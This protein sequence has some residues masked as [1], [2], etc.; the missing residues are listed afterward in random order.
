MTDS[1]KGLPAE[2]QNLVLNNKTEKQNRDLGQS[3]FLELMLTQMQNQDPL[4]PMESGDFLSQLAQFGTVNGITELQNSFSTLAE[5]LQS[6]QALQA[7]TLVG[8]SVS[9]AGNQ[10]PL[11][12][13]A[14]TSGSVKLDI[15]VDSMKVLI[16]DASGQLVRQLSFGPQYAGEIKF[17]WDGLNEEGAAMPSGQYGIS[18]IGN[19]GGEDIS[20]NTLVHA[21]VESVTLANGSQPML[22]LGSHGTVNISDIN[23]FF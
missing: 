9:L 10:L 17:D 18:A 21:S 22:N 16:T 3:E 23:E 14:T 19:I 5:Q 20:F 6:S 8:R 2:L 15:P 13:G 1:I 7:S 12:A 4:N 11:T